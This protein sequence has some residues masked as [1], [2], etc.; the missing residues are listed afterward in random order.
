VQIPA[1]AMRDALLAAGVPP[2]VADGYEEL[3]GGIAR[4]IDA[5]DFAAEPFSAE[6]AGTTT[7]QIFAEQVLRPAFERQFAAQA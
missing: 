7:L 4:H 1:P 2:L 5:G 3:F 6:N